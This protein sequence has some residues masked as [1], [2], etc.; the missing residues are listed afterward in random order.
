MLW[1][2]SWTHFLLDS[3]EYGIMWLWPLSSKVYALKDP[4]LV[5]PIYET[6]FIPYWWQSVRKYT[7]F[8]SFYLEVLIIITALIIYYK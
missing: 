5:L 2:G 1:L 4:E 7:K 6:R 3:I 8:Y